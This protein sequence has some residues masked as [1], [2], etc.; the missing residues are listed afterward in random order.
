MGSNPASPTGKWPPSQTE[1]VSRWSHAV[2]PAPATAPRFSR[3]VPR[4]APGA[5]RGHP[6]SLVGLWTRAAPEGHNGGDPPGGNR[7]VPEVGGSEPPAE[8]IHKDT[9]GPDQA[10]DSVDDLAHL[11]GRSPVPADLG[12][13]ALGLG[14][15]PH[16]LP[17][18]SPPRQGQRVIRGEVPE[19]A[20]QAYGMGCGGV[21]T[22]PTQRRG[23]SAWARMMSGGRP[24][25]WVTSAT[26]RQW[27]VTS[28][29]GG[30]DG[31]SHGADQRV[32]PAGPGDYSEPEVDPGRGPGHGD[33]QGA[34]RRW[35][36]RVPNQ[37]GSYP[38]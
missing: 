10:S 24:R 31:P 30:R 16:L 8:G 18:S 5:L 22:I 33:R 4:E 2:R 11:P 26:E 27:T 1:A 20:R 9:D 7:M 34:A 37:A 35:L 14:H 25:R 21:D 29:G 6:R 3:A 23:S 28:G 15:G 19:K 12:V 13:T 36:R 32:D 38:R 17:G